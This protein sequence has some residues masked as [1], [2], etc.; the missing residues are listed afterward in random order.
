VGASVVVTAAAGLGALPLRSPSSTSKADATPGRATVSP[1]LRVAGGHRATVTG[2]AALSRPIARP[3][4]AAVPRTRRRHAPA[5]A[6]HTAAAV[7]AGAAAP[8]AVAPSQPVGSP[9]PAAHG[10]SSLPRGRSGLSHGKSS[11][12]PG[13]KKVAGAQSAAA[14]SAG[15][16]KTKPKQVPPGQAGTAGKSASAPGHLKSASPAE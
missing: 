7:Q 5:P 1:A 15:T 10:K 14:G 4:A 16:D 13:H 8:P 9:S 6:D 3:P 12:A 11:E 2:P